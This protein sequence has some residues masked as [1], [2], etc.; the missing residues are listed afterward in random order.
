MTTIY[1]SARS[2]AQEKSLGDQELSD[3]LVKVNSLAMKQC[4][5]F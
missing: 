2:A 5:A 1:E 4:P 3:L